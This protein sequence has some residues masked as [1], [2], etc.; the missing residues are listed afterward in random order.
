M[1]V[2]PDPLMLI[3]FVAIAAMAA[4]LGFTVA[5]GRT[6]AAKAQVDALTDEL[7]AA[8]SSR[9]R[10]VA[11]L[12]DEALAE[13]AR[14]EETNERRVKAETALTELDPARKALTAAQSELADAKAE[15]ARLTSD[16]AAERKAAA[17]KLTL[18]EDAQAK[19]GQAF[20]ALSKSAL[21]RNNQSFLALAREQ[22]TQ[23]Q[24]STQADLDH[25]QKAIVQIVD[26]VTKSLEKMD[27]HL[28]ELES[29]RSTAYGE[30]SQQVK[31]LTA[32]QVGLEG[33][34]RKLVQALRSSNV[35]GQWGEMQLQRVVELAGL[36]EHCDFDQQV[37]VFSDADARLRPDMVVHLPGGKT[38]VVDAKATL[39][40]YLSL[41]QAQDEAQRA[42]FQAKVAADVRTRIKDLSK[43]SYWDRFANSPEFVV[44]FLPGEGLFATALHQDPTLFE[45]GVDGNVVL[46]SPTTLIALLRAVAF[47]W[48]QEALAEN[49]RE[50]T[51]LG[52]DLYDR[53]ATMGKNFASLGSSLTSAVSNYNKTVGSLETRVL[54]SARRFRDLKVTGDTDKLPP[55]EMIEQTS[56]P[57]TAVELAPPPG[58]DEPPPVLQSPASSATG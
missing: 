5:A 1:P 38:I 49:A 13:R 47:G 33:E 29:K 56:R 20:E 57:L 42:T 54:P 3:L 43:K 41:I 4:G 51:A 35:R 31:S 26:P 23:L 55:A 58:G 45:T 6:K 34:T 9:D 39:D 7:A 40:A 10:I 21:D 12:R 53:L 11:D 50:I 19:L 30:L 15:I 36:Q 14:R 24:Q 44:L 32:S 18:L 27:G 48:R 52:K 2:A 37:T 46:A 25:R 8:R 16:L 28:R 22:F 17:E